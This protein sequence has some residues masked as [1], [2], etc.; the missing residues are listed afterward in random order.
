[1]IGI[2]CDDLTMPPGRHVDV[3]R[4]SVR[5]QLLA[6]SLNLAFSLNRLVRSFSRTV[7]TDGD[8]ARL[9]IIG[10]VLSLSVC[11]ARGSSRPVAPESATVH[12][13]R[14][15]AADLA[16]LNFVNSMAAGPFH[17]ETWKRACGVRQVSLSAAH[18]LT[19]GALITPRR[20]SYAGIWN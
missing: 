15:R 8:P 10:S 14:H 4:H 13:V 20:S 12:P 9:I 3:F 5:S 7:S 11:S 1:M 18:Q 2:F 17:L 6:V 19:A 16:P